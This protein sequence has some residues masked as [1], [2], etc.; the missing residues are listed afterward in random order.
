MKIE[1]DENIQ[2][3]T[4]RIIKECKISELIFMI[5]VAVFQGS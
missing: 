5:Y 2:A 1:A 3:E 4:E